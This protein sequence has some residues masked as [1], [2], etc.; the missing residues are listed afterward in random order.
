MPYI[1]I[2]SDTSTHLS[3]LKVST[4]V[5]K[6]VQVI[7]NDIHDLF[8]AIKISTTLPD[9]RFYQSLFHPM[10]YWSNSKPDL[11]TDKPINV[12]IH[13]CPFT[14]L[15]I[16]SQEKAIRQRI[17]YQAL[18]KDQLIIKVSKDLDG[19]NFSL[20]QESVEIILTKNPGAKPV[21]NIFVSYDVRENFHSLVG[22]LNDYILPALTDLTPRE[23][24]EI[25]VKSF[26]DAFTNREIESI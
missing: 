26:V 9:G 22:R 10:G 5:I 15:Q 19:Y 11:R 6:E 23:L 3:I 14:E 1:D 16:D 8:H 12:S 20:P 21:R 13:Y 24:D 7:G 17:I 18:I 2:S 25:K 4:I